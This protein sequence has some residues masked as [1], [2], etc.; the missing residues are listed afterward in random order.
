MPRRCSGG[1]ARAKNS[2]RKKKKKKKKKKARSRGE[3]RKGKAGMGE[4]A[5]GSGRFCLSA[6][7]CGAVRCGGGGGSS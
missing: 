1:R 3:E 5:T 6:L 2:K 7:R 4:E